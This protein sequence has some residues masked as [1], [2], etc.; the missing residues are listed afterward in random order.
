MAEPQHFR[1]MPPAPRPA[2]RQRLPALIRSGAACLAAGCLLRLAA[3]AEDAAVTVPTGD[4]A[5]DE[6]LLAELL[7]E[8]MPSVWTPSGSVRVGGGY[9]DNVLLSSFS[10]VGA[11]FVTVGGDLLLHRAPTDGTEVSVLASGDY[12]L[13]ID[14]PAADPEGLALFQ[15]DV[16]RDLGRD[17]RTGFRGQY[18]FLNQ[19]FDVSATEV[20]LSTVTARGHTATLG[21][22]VSKGLGDLWTLEAAVEGV[23]QLFD[24][25]LDDY[26][27]LVPAVRVRREL[28]ARGEA[29][30]VY[31]FLPRWYDSRPPLDAEGNALP[32]R[33]EFLAQEVELRPQIHWDAAKRWTTTLR[34]GALGNTDNGGGYFDYW[35]YGA[36]LQ[37]RYRTE[38]LTAR[39][40]VRGRWYDYQVQH[41]DGAGSPWRDKTDVAVTARLEYRPAGRWTVFAQYDTESTDD[42]VPDSSYEAAT[43]LAGV[44][45]EL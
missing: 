3:G 12:T 40:E 15:A 6:R 7:D 33:L 20:D 11:G 38:R 31:R 21:P 4:P 34:L 45:W 16:K 43:I 5:L 26:W 35:R 23:R 22:S 27:E 10:P 41:S 18:L 29:G 19:V 9:R 36:G 44:E 37:V 13:F 24:E 28:G 42:T 2:P 14:E 1:I 30:L 8:S 17:W 32:G 39:I 25:P